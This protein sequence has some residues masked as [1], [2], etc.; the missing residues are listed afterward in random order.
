MGQWQ[1]TADEIGQMSHLQSCTVRRSL[2]EPVKV[3]QKELSVSQAR[4]M[5]QQA[6]Q[7]LPLGSMMEVS[8]ARRP[9]M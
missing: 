9:L 8:E 1:L 4:S 7:V 3:S 2:L 5:T 6:R